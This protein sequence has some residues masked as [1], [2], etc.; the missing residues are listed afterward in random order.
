MSVENE[1]KYQRERRIIK[2]VEDEKERQRKRSNRN[3]KIKRWTS[4]LSVIAIC[5]LTTILVYNFLVGPVTV[6]IAST[7]VTGEGEFDKIVV[8]REQVGDSNVKIL[9]VV[10][11]ELNEEFISAPSIYSFYNRSIVFFI[12]VYIDGFVQPSEHFVLRTEGTKVIACKNNITISFA[13]GV[14]NDVVVP[15][16][17]VNPF[18]FAGITIV[19]VV[20]FIGFLVFSND[21]INERWRDSWY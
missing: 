19:G 1:T 14:M 17:E 7:A 18:T 12:T 21:V 9:F 8:N 3:N 15:F 4:K 5:I 6:N 20:V 10:I 2:E 11:E 13:F 16:Y